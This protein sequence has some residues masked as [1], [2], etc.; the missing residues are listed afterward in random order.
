MYLWRDT[1][2]LLLNEVNESI[3]KH[4]AFHKHGRLKNKNVLHAKDTDGKL[5][6]ISPK[7]PMPLASLMLRLS[8]LWLGTTRGRLSK[9][10]AQ[11]QFW[12]CI[13]QNE[14]LTICLNGWLCE[15]NSSVLSRDSL[16]LHSKKCGCTFAFDKWNIV[17]RS[18]NHLTH[19]IVDAEAIG[20][21]KEMCVMNPSLSSSC[22]KLVFLGLCIYCFV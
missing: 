17:C 20:R 22:N 15:R 4:S 16:A 14:S 10:R 21:F 6:H 8:W 18:P 13:C 19:N 7:L 3:I 1:C 11:P 12:Q 2:N 5:S 9:T